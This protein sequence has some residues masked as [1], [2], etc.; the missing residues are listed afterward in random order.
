MHIDGYRGT[1]KSTL[2]FQF[3]KAFPDFIFGDLDDTLEEAIA[4]IGVCESIDRYWT[5]VSTA[6]QHFLDKW[7]LE[8]RKPI[9]LVGN[10]WLPEGLFPP[11]W[12]YVAISA[13]RKYILDVHP[14][15][16]AWRGHKQGEFSAF[17]ALKKLVCS[18]SAREL[19][20]ADIQNIQQLNAALQANGYTF[21]S[22]SQI[23]EELDVLSVS[24]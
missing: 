9:I 21:R 5:L 3:Q 1:G 22:A 15:R 6:H 12:R 17:S 19:F 18:R 24:L 7:I 11:A 8:Q 13:E 20:Q 10:N 16:V 14:I 4:Q 2:M 23:Y